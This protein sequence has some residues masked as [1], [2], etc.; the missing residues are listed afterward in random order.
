MAFRLN[1][2][3]VPL[4]LFSVDRRR[5]SVPCQLLIMPRRGQLAAEGG[6]GRNR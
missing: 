2:A 1:L 3:T 5:A 6:C 4:V